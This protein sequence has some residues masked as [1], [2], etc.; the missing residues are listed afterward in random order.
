MNP[1]VLQRRGG[2]K[3]SPVLG[4]DDPMEQDSGQAYAYQ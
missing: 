3:R 1:L 4:L 2:I